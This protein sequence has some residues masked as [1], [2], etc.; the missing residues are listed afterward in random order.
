MQL[1][2][3]LPSPGTASLLLTLIFA[4]PSPVYSF[5]LSNSPEEALP[6]SV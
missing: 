3:I 5:T 1:L 4:S 6:D 2:R